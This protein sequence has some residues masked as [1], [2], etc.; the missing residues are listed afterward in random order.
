MSTEDSV[1]IWFGI[2][3]GIVTGVATLYGLWREWQQ[4]RLNQVTRLATAAQTAV[5]RTESSI[6][7]PLLSE[8][9]ANTVSEFVQLHPSQDAIRFRMLLFRDLHRTMR[10]SED[11]KQLAKSTATNHLISILQEMPSPPLHVHTETEIKKNIQK[12]QECIETAYGLRPRAT[13]ELMQQLALFSGAV[14]TM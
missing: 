14:G 6:V 1:V 7:R 4:Y 10:L 11:E 9:M 13:L 3:T 8:R 12:V 2:G 5:R